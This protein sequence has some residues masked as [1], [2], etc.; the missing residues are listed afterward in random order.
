MAIAVM[1]A[2]V[3]LRLDTDTDVDGVHHTMSMLRS[4]V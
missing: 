1:A 3:E 4:R 2:A